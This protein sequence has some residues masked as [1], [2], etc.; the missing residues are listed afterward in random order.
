MVKDYANAEKNL[1]KITDN[2]LFSKATII[3]KNIERCKEKPME[4]L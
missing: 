2:Q 4:C 3:R 1:K